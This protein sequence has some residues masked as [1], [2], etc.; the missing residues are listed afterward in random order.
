MEN[1]V[2]LSLVSIFSPISG[3]IAILSYTLVFPYRSLKM[4][5]S[6]IMSRIEYLIPTCN[7]LVL[8]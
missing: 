3:L 2:K 8:I 5:T 6:Q 7:T 1:R 4:I